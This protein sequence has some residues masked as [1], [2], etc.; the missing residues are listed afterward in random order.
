[1]GKIPIFGRKGW[2]DEEI[3]WEIPETRGRKFFDL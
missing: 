3:R 1:M 2:A